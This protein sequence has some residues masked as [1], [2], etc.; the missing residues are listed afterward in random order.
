MTAITRF[1]GDYAF[2]SNF[3]TALVM[4]DGMTYPTVEHAYQA[5]KTL[6]DDLRLKIRNAATP[7]L[8]KKMGKSITLHPDWN[9]SKLNIMENLL[10]QKFAYPSLR[11][12]LLA[13]KDKELVEGN[14]W[15]DL[16]F[17]KCSCIKHNNSGENHLGKILMRLREYYKE[18]NE[19]TT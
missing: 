15:H 6:D 19:S 18:L 14:Y 7:A 1:T 2:L 17:G 3:H 12:K 9:T 10:I 16:Y 13:T 4:L 5:A 11:E 8:A